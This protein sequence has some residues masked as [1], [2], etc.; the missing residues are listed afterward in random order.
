MSLER[1][2]G[3]AA[4][5]IGYDDVASRS[6]GGRGQADT[7]VK[8]PPRLPLRS[9]YSAFVHVLKL[10]LPALAVALVLLV[11]VW[12]QFDLGDS[13]FRVGVSK[14][15]PESAENLSMLNA[16]FQGLDERGRPFTITADVATQE[17]AESDVVY[18]D[19]P[20]GDL[21]LEDE[22]WLAVTARK[23]VYDRVGEFLTLQGGVNIFHDQGYHLE[24]EEARVDL[25]AGRAVSDKPTHAQGP[26]GTVD[27]QGIE[28]TDDGKRI[29]FT[30]K[31]RLVIYP[32]QESDLR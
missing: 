5:A 12:P 30:G 2:T 10:V 4:E 11:V 28:L 29:F 14:L 31:S 19:L 13:G 1:Q 3:T 6:A 9:R 18:L 32:D 17:T 15:Q 8:R 27:S 21:T 25:E 23:G 16:R 22:S 24:T 26:F 7:A 20:K